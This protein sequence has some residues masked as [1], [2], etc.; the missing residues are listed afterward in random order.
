MDYH[1]EIGIIL[2]NLSTTPYT[3]N[4]GDRIAQLVMAEVVKIEFS[5]VTEFNEKTERG[6]GGFGHTGKD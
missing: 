4:P 5:E 1:G 3:I 2:V 6:S